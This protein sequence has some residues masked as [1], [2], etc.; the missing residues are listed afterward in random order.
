MKSIG[1]LLADRDRCE[2]DAYESIVRH[3]NIL[4]EIILCNNGFLATDLK[5]EDI[6]RLEKMYVQLNTAATISLKKI[7]RYQAV[8]TELNFKLTKLQDE[9]P[10]SKH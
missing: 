4:L 10:A 6:I 2:L 7:K 3:K 5:T 8:L 9:S 1:E